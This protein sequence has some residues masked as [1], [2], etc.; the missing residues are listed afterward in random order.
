[1]HVYNIYNTYN[2]FTYILIANTLKI[3]PL[4]KVLENFKQ[5]ILTLFYVLILI[6]P[7]ALVSV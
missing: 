5:F 2:I 4:R 7:N 3:I 1:M 6:K